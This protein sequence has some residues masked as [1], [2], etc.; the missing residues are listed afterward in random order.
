MPVNDLEL[1]AFLSLDREQYRIEEDIYL[2]VEVMNTSEDPVSFYVSPYKLNNVKLY[3]LNL[4]NGLILDE[5]YSRILENNDLKKE[6]PELFEYT[7]KTL[8]PDEV[9]KFRINL[10]EYFDLPEP[11]RYKVKL[12]FDPFANSTLPHKIMISNPLFFVLKDSIKDEAFNNM[13]LS[14]KK[15]EEEKTYTPQ[16]TIEFMLNAYQKGN[17]DGYFLYQ[18]LNAVIMQYDKFR[19]RYLKASTVMKQKIIS[20]FKEWIMSR[21]E[22]EIEK[23][24]ILDVYHSLTDKSS[25][26]KCKVT[27]KSPALFKTYIYKYKLIQKGV[28][29]IVVDIDVQTY[30]KE[31]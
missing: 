26:V 12:E 11:G 27:Y 9:Y 5:K 4:Q 28:K 18:D 7:T 19:D 22:K 13:I 20:E 8:Y 25:V 6:K 2:N 1:K 23:Y 16:G 24:D 3:I 14:L 21:P 15:I 10:P 17:W 31:K 29:W 30:S